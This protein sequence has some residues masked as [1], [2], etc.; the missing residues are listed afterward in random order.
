MIGDGDVDDPS[1]LVPEN[2]EHK[3]EPK[4][5]RRYDEQVG[6]HDLACVIG[7]EGP[8]RL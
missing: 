8:P 2:H 5:D 1:T 6:S 4:R 3:E 7:E